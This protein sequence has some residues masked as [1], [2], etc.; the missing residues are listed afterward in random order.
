[1][2][3]VLGLITARGG[4]KGVP[5]KN[6]RKVAGKPLIAWSIQAAA[7]SEQLSRVVVS[8]DDK[9]I[10]EVSRKWGADVPFIRPVELAMDRSPHVPVLEHA[11]KWLEAHENARFDYVML[12][13]PTSPLRSSEDIDNAINLAVEHDADGVTS[14]CE[15]PSHPY[16]T[17]HIVDGKL[18]DFVAH[19]AGY[20]PR[21]ELP[22][23]YALN[24]A[25]YLVRSSVLM[26]HGILHPEDTRPYLMPAER[27]LQ[28]DEPWDL[29]LA[30]LVLKDRET[31]RDAT[32]I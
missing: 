13:Q 5:G 1:M 19:P 15:S 18:R 27:S 23:V 16:L 7:Q 8:T 17:K 22:P 26:E 2:A 21:Q 31:P 6:I 29:Y 24:G 12:L 4:S 32:E 10:A 28:I 11:V 9:E 30:D 25:I 20:L 14:I 3:K